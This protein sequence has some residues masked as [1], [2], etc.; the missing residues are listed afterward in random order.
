MIDVKPRVLPK[1]LAP[2]RKDTLPM[3]PA[4]VRS[5]RE[6]E[7]DPWPWLERFAGLSPDRELQAGVS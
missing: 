5:D 4:P 3:P 7:D 1:L 2:A 6:S